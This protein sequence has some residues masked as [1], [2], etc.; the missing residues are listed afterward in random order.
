MWS[1][2]RTDQGQQERVNE[3]REMG[4]FDMKSSSGDVRVILRILPSRNAAPMINSFGAT[5][6]FALTSVKSP[7]SIPKKEER[8]FR[9]FFPSAGCFMRA[10]DCSAE[11]AKPTSQCTVSMCTIRPIRLVFGMVAMPSMARA[12]SLL[13]RYLLLALPF[14]MVTSMA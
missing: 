14:L 3:R 11:K 9:R 8:V 7:D 12:R 4:E 2:V 1:R 5:F 6:F 13:F 10:A